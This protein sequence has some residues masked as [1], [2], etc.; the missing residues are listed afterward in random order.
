MTEIE[1]GI[2][3]EVVTRLKTTESVSLR[4][5]EDSFEETLLN[6]GEFRSV[7]SVDG[8]RCVVSLSKNA[9]CWTPFTLQRN[10]ESSSSSSE[11]S[12][13][14]TSSSSTSTQQLAIT[15][16][17]SRE[18]FQGNVVLDWNDACIL[19]P[20]LPKGFVIHC[21]CIN[22]KDTQSRRVYVKH[23]FSLMGSDGSFPA[24]AFDPCE[25]PCSGWIRVIRMCMKEVNGDNRVR[26]PLLVV[27]NPFSGI[28]R[29]PQVWTTECAPLFD[30]AGL[31]YTV[32]ET[33]H[34][35]H[36]YDEIL[37]ADLS[38]YSAIV[39]V[40][41][42]G[43]VNEVLNG[44]MARSDWATACH[45]PL[46]SIAAGTGNAICHTLYNSIIPVCAVCHVVKN[47]TM[48]VDAFLA[49]QP[50]V[51]QYLW[52]VLNCSYGIVA[53]ADFG[54]EKIRWAGSL[55]PSIW[56]VY[57]ILCGSMYRCR[58]TYL[59]TDRPRS[60]WHGTRC[61]RDCA[62]CRNALQETADQQSEEAESSSSEEK[63]TN[64]D[65]FPEDETLSDHPSDADSE[66]SVTGRAADDPV[67]SSVIDGKPDE[68]TDVDDQRD[69]E[70][71]E[72]EEEEEEEESQEQT[73]TTSALVKETSFDQKRAVNPVPPYGPSFTSSL[74]QTSKWTEDVPTKYAG[75]FGGYPHYRIGGG[76]PPNWT[77]HD[78][79]SLSFSVFQKMPW[80]MPNM[81][82]TPYSHI[83]DGCMDVA[84]ATNEAF[85]RIRFLHFFNTLADSSHANHPKLT[86][87][88]VR[89][90]TL[91]PLD[92]DGYVG[93]DGERI[94]YAPTQFHIA[95]GLVNFFCYQ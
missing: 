3:E 70:A 41:G 59:P 79:L 4:D 43:T 33:T 76:L 36:A 37:N 13:T 2:D 68:L 60:G 28:K 83:S 81:C 47:V 29:G 54:S 51:Q 92:G 49:A 44:I 91:E 39:A 22:E 27:V 74:T 94:S 85:S 77:V 24:P 71:E 72:E 57:R 87:V 38:Q 45:I 30:A 42:D 32:L 52:G 5:E 8:V 63:G 40:G 66:S 10:S 50:T 17:Y 75:L 21:L 14:S 20:A 1:Q 84:Y 89:A 69:D 53:E 26:N 78:N 23:E 88:K 67:S 7:F 93:V 86:Y 25:G 16:G 58:L 80:L 35:G 95:Q 64:E 6:G 82:A 90:F 73:E 55:R 9:L 61:G 15:N 18:P 48:R 56:A 34:A 46:A 31:R 19:V 12:T 11:S 62:Y 65:S